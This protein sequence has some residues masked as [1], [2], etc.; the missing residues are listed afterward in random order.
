MRSDPMRRGLTVIFV[1]LLAPPLVEAQQY[2]AFWADAFHYGFK[3]PQQIDQ[4]IEDV[5]AAKCN[6]IFAEV[7]RRGDSYYLHSPEPPAAD[8]DYAPG[9]DA[10]QYLIDRAHARNIAVHA[11]FPITPLW[12]D[13]M[14]PP[15]PGH[16]WYRHGPN[17]VGDDMWMTIDSTGKVGTALDPGH[18]DAL[19]YLVD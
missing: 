16:L 8:P 2:R 11:W 7:R 1:L 3:T 19:Q 4:M 15:D 5:T 12:S 9:F 17:A 14:P 6:S 18:P 10:L 13:S